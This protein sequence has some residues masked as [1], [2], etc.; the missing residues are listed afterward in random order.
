MSER[1]ANQI[2]GENSMGKDARAI[3]DRVLETQGLL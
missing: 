3:V 2:M 1:E